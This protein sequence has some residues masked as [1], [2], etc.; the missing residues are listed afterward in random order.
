VADVLLHQ[1]DDHLP[2]G[3][4]LLGAA[5]HVGNPVERLLRRR[6]VVTAEANKTIGTLMSRRS[7]P[8]LGPRSRRR[9]TRCCRR[10]DFV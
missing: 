4:D 10:R 7:K 5:I 2:A 1:A 8:L 3:L 6:D 9:T